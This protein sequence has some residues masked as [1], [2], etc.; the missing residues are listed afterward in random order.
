MRSG[1]KTGHDLTYALITPARNE[2]LYIEETLRSVVSQT[3][4]PLR[5]IIV[6]DGSTDRTDQIVDTYARKYES[7]QLLRLPSERDRNFAAK[8]TAFNAGYKLLADVP[9]DIVGNLDADLSFD[10]DYFRYLLDKF[11]EFPNLGVAGTPF[12]EDGRRYDYRFTNI[13][14]VSG[15][16]QLFRR[17]CFDQ[18]GGYVPIRSGGIDWVAVT[19]ARMK[20][21][22]TRTFTGRVLLHQRKMGTGNTNL[23]WS[24]FKRGQEDYVLGGHPVWQVAR[25][26]YQMS[27]RPYIAGGLLLLT[28]YAHAAAKRMKRPI[29]AD[30]VRFHRTEQMIR[31]RRAASRLT[32]AA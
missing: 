4:Q 27:L 6:S 2:E 15:A 19:T 1:V 9:Y 23:W 32:K 11:A 7:I 12:V 16:C 22:K 13:E 28:G 20:G 30:L 18:L 29:S 14:H 31:L 3:H 21:W 25:C 5:W 24:F 10:S 26:A 8:A 17:E